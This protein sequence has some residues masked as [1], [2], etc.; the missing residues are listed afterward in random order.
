MEYATPN[1]PEWIT[2]K[3]M[4]IQVKINGITEKTGK[5]GA[6]LAV[7]TDKGNINAFEKEDMDLARNN[8]G[9]TIT[10]DLVEKNGYLN[11]KHAHQTKTIT[12]GMPQAYNPAD[13][14]LEYVKLSCDIWKLLRTDP[15]KEQIEDIGL[16]DMAARLVKEAKKII[17]E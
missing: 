3:K 1:Y 10:W 7:N 2:A 12:N 13:S 14:S 5:K 15:A 4:E 16:M 9:K 8:L 11:I 6:Y 17:E